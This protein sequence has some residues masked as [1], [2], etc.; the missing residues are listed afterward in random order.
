MEKKYS[1]WVGG[2]EVNSYLLKKEEAEEIAQS[3]IEQG[4][5]EVVIDDYSLP[6][7]YQQFNY[8]NENG[9]ALDDNLNEFR[10]ENGAAVYVPE[11]NWNLFEIINQN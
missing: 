10:D 7:I 1:V 8:I 4:Y 11:E 3:W 9:K 5:D 6:E 2:G